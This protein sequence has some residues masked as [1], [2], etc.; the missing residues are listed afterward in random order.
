ML[1]RLFFGFRPSCVFKLPSWAPLSC[2]SR[3]SASTRVPCYLT[4]GAC[5]GGC[6]SFGPES[7][8]CLNILTADP[9][10]CKVRA[11]PLKRTNEPRRGRRLLKR[12]SQTWDMLLIEI[13]SLSTYSD[14]KL[15]LVPPCAPLSCTNVHTVL[16]P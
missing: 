14:W 8:V 5:I 1:G 2:S 6:F 13:T 11:S 10:K 12:M 3:P 7:T 16:Q 9:G 15:P 4:W